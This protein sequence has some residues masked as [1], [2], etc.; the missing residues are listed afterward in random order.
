MF[1]WMFFVISKSDRAEPE[2]SLGNRL[3][4]TWQRCLWERRSLRTCESAQTCV[5]FYCLQT[6]TLLFVLNPC[7]RFV[8][9]PKQIKLFTR[10]MQRKVLSMIKHIR[11]TQV[12]TTTHIT[13][14]SHLKWIYGERNNNN[15]NTTF[16]LL[17][18]WKSKCQNWLE[19]QVRA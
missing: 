7:Q 1:S 3:M 9:K 10:K 16:C 8:I 19:S 13:H 4:V 11:P 2:R 6:T 12:N 15:N 14:A 5:F 17:D 18:F